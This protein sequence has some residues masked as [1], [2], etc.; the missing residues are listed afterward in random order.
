MA[1]PR[2]FVGVAAVNRKYVEISMLSPDEYWLWVAA[3]F[4]THLSTVPQGLQ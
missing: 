3:A 4:S 1:T 2:S